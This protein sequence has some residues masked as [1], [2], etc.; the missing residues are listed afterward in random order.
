MN[1][2]NRILE[3]DS[4]RGIAALMVLF[5]H[6]TILSPNGNFKFV[7]GCTAVD[8]F[9]LISGFVIF[10]STNNSTLE[11]IINRISRLYPTYWISVTFTFL[12]FCIYES[13]KSN[14]TIHIDFNKYIAN[15]T[16]FQ[17]YFHIKN[18]DESYWTLILE[19][20]FYLTISIF[21]CFNL[22]KHINYIALFSIIII[23]FLKYNSMN[24]IL[25]KLFFIL[26]FLPFLPL[27]FAGIL[28]SQIYN[29]KKDLVIKYSIILI[30]VLCQVFNYKYTCSSFFLEINY[31]IVMIFIYFLLFILLVNNKLKFIISKITLF[32]G[33]ISFA[34]YLTHQSLSVEFIVPYLTNSLKMNFWISTIGIALPISILIATLI[35]FKFEKYVNVKLKKILKSLLLKPSDNNVK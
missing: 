7:Y 22:L 2:K 35:T 9:F 6:L 3:L 21:I 29:Q 30:C 33:K 32:F 18:I 17:K 19:L 14:W 24:I 13:K 34:L 31:Y 11:F 26:P 5:F 10:N 8:L 20:I 4:L 25:D 12:L 1:F 15:M 28:F 27:F 16:M 23:A